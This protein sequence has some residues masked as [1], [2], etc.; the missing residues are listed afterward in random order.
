MQKLVNKPKDLQKLVD[1]TKDVASNNKFLQNKLGRSIA[2]ATQDGFKEAGLDT[3]TNKGFRNAVQDIY[4]NKLL[5]SGKGVNDAD[6]AD[7]MAGK[8]LQTPKKAGVI[9][10]ALNTGKTAKNAGVKTAQGAAALEGARGLI[11]PTKNGDYTYSNEGAS[12]NSNYNNA[13]RAVN[14]YLDEAGDDSLDRWYLM[15]YGTQNLVG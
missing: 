10:R 5:Q 15:Q 3:A 12:R 11:A 7:L 1:V 6:L 8:T 13:L 2:N 14:D 9:S 4:Q